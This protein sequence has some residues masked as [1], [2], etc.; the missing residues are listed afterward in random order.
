[1]MR[2]MAKQRDKKYVTL[3]KR[4]INER[5]VKALLAEKGWTQEDLAHATGITLS[6]LSRIIR[7][8][9]QVDRHVVKI[10]NALGVAPR[11][12]L[13][14]LSSSSSFF[15]GSGGRALAASSK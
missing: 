12:I 3:P 5:H 6:Y 8:Q 9:R 7:N 15:S 10:A 13:E 14:P 2:D 1:M 4:Q 11:H